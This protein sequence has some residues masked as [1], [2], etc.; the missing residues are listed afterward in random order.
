MVT[1][2]ITNNCTGPCSFDL[3]GI[4]AGAI[5]NNTGQSE[6]LTVAPAR[7]YTATTATSIRAA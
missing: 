3:Q 6:T 2:V 5:L 7:A 1:F 4:K